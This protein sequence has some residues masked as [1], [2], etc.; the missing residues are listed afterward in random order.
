[1]RIFRG[2]D[3]YIARIGNKEF[4]YDD[5]ENVI[6]GLIPELESFGFKYM[7]DEND[8]IKPVKKEDI[9][10]A[11]R[12]MHNC[13]TYKGYEGFLNTYNEE[14][15]IMEIGFRD[16]DGKALGIK[17]WIDEYDK[18]MVYYNVKVPDDEVEAIYEIRKQIKGFPFTCPEKVYHKKDGVW[19]PWHDYGTPL[20]EGEWI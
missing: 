2:P 4:L 16:E 13:V 5:S 12:V 8:Y 3:E 14:T 9:D 1:M 20:K 6:V 17:P 11:Y 18:N 15:H 10:S 7:Q 19:I